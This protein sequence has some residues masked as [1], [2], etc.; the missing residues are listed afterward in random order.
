MARVSNVCVY[1]E[2][3]SSGSLLRTNLSQLEFGHAI[4]TADFCFQSRNVSVVLLK[5]HIFVKIFTSHSARAVCAE[6][7]C[8]FVYALRAAAA[9]TKYDSPALDNFNY[10]TK[11]DVIG[12]FCELFVYRRRDEC[13]VSILSCFQTSLQSCQ[14]CCVMTAPP[15]TSHPLH[16]ISTTYVL[17]SRVAQ[18]NHTTRSSLVQRKTALLEGET[19][20]KTIVSFVRHRSQCSN[21]NDKN[22]TPICNVIDCDFMN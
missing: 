12:H 18:H 6:H 22:S 9:Q 8:L 11:R 20:L 7:L 17:P 14:R 10:A 5:L 1:V 2:L 13:F 19:P 15:N 21:D 16:H 4:S 3:I